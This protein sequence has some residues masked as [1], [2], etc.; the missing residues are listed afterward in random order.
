MNPA[1][2]SGI[3]RKKNIVIV[4]GVVFRRQGIVANRPRPVRRNAISIAVV[5]GLALEMLWGVYRRVA[6]DATNLVAAQL[7][8]QA[9][10]DRI[11]LP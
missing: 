5:T 2:K 7:R 6:R 1:M 8:H 4:M 10:M 11:R 9:L 3:P